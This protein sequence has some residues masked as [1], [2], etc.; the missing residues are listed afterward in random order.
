MKVILP[1]PNTLIAMTLV[2]GMGVV[3]LDN[4]GTIL[5]LSRLLRK[6]V[7]ALNLRHFAH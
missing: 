2:S 7:S 1:A 6:N 4:T 3:I 5:S